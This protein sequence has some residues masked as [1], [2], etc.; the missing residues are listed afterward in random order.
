MIKII[1]GGEGGR[2]VISDESLTKCMKCGRELYH[3]DWVFWCDINKK[4]FCDNLKCK[5][6]CCPYEFTRS[7]HED[8]YCVLKL[9]DEESVKKKEKKVK[10]IVLD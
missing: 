1:E 3:N 2:K 10:N 4:I 7:I 5:Q 6:Q 8:H 9:I